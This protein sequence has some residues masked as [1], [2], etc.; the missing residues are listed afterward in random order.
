MILRVSRAY[1][2]GIRALR[3]S[4]SLRSVAR[5]FMKKGFLKGK[6]QFKDL[7]SEHVTASGLY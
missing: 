3:K 4:Y 5:G 2:L 1:D 7:N 6:S